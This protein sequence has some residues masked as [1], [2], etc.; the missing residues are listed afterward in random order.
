MLGGCMGLFAFL[1]LAQLINPGLGDN[2]FN[3]LNPGA[4]L[5]TKWLP[6]FFVPGLAML[7]LAPSMG[8]GIEVVKVLG[9]VIIGM[10]YTM[11][12]T[13]FSVL[14]I[15][16]A[17]GL[18]EKVDMSPVVTKKEDK[19]K[20][21]IGAT[22]KPSKAFSDEILKYALKGAAVSAVVSLTATKAKFSLATPLNT[23][24]LGFVTLSAFIWTS[25]LPKAITTKAHPIVLTTVLI[26][27]IFQ[28]T[29]FVIGSSFTDVLKSYKFG[30]LNFMQ[31]GAGDFLL[32]MLGPAVVSFSMSMY[33]QKKLLKDNLFVVLVAVLISSAGSL[34]GTAAFVR[35]IKL[36]GD[37]DNFLRRSVL[38]R[39]VTAAL[40]MVITEILDG[41]VAIG[42]SVVVLTGIAAATYGRSILDAMG[43]K[44]PVSRGLG[45]GAGGQ[46]L[47][48]ASLAGEAEAFPFAAVAFVFN[49]ILA[50]SLIT[51]PAFK[52]ALLNVMGS[53]AVP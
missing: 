31:A 32:Y 28:L 19:T 47:G 46:S 38:A 6:V 25:R 10:I 3:S 41:N 2:I 23:I 34:F 36:G 16:T 40:A 21:P 17:L 5:L 4:K 7:P 15:R 27:S 22:T 53:G 24:Y 20:T 18:V 11:A 50:T 12:T 45:M 14:G 13:G 43:L 8:G 37:G 48:A 1:I 26:L 42:A 35:L 33:S 51:I 29:G 52:T 44:D 9:V 39:N 49:A 30:S